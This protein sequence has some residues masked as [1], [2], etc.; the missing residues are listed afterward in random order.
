MYQTFLLISTNWR[1]PDLVLSFLDDLIRTVSPRGAL[2]LTAEVTDRSSNKSSRMSGDFYSLRN[3]LGKHLVDSISIGSM[4]WRPDRA[5]ELYFFFEGE[6]K[7]FAGNNAS[8]DRMLTFS[9]GEETW[10]LAVKEGRDQ[11]ILSLVE[12]FF[13]ATDCFYG[14]GHRREMIISGPFDVLD[15]VP[16]QPACRIIDREW[17]EIT[18]VY[19]YNYFSLPLLNK[20]K[21][22]EALCR[23][24]SVTCKALVSPANETVGLAIYL[25]ADEGRALPGIAAECLRLIRSSRVQHGA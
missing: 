19:E 5:A 10:R 3:K 14:F 9:V 2:R 18:D 16:D 17:T 23:M 11:Q 6:R 22:S 12:Q 1:D 21:D 24:D 4:E 20:F 7:A 13:S 8:A 15:L 25:K